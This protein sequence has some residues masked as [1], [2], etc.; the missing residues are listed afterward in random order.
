MP[1]RMGQRISRTA[2]ANRGGAAVR[3]SLL[4]LLLVAAPALA[5]AEI[6]RFLAQLQP[7]DLVPGADRFG[8]IAGDPPAAPAYRGDEL[9][10]YVFLNSDA[11]NSSGYSGKPIHIAVGMTPQGQIT[12]AMLLEHHEPIVLIGIPEKRMTGFIQDY[13]GLDVLG[14]T[15]ADQSPVDAI[16]GATVTVMVIDDTLRRASRRVLHAMASGATGASE[17]PRRRLDLTQSGSQGWDQLLAEASVS[18]LRLTVGDVNEAFEKLG[19]KAAQRRERGAAGETFIDL[20]VALASAP[21]VGR[22]LL[23]GNEYRLLR[24]RLEAGHHAV[25]IGGRGRYSW[26]GS[27]YVRG[28][29]FDR[30]KLIQGEEVIR[31]RDSDYKRIGDFVAEGAPD[32]PEIGLFTLPPGVTFDPSQPWRLELLVQRA[33]GALE[34]RFIAFD[35]TYT[36]PDKYLQPAARPV[37][38]VTATGEA[39]TPAVEQ[40][41][42]QRLWQIK[43]LQIAILLAGLAVLTLIF[44]FQDWL[45][46]RPKLT[47]RVRI[48]FLL[49]TLLWI[50]WY[51]DAQLSVVNVLALFNALITDFSWDYF[52]VDPLVFILWTAVAASLLFWGRGPFCGWLCPFGALQELL[53]RVAK[54]LRVPQYLVP[55]GLHE[56]LWP[57]KY[58]IF[59]GLFGVSLYSLADAEVFAEVEPFKTA[60]ILDFV[61]EWPFVVYAAVLL[62]AGLFIERFFCRYLCPL[63]AALAIPGRLRMFEWLKRYHQ[64]GNPCQR[65]ANECMVQSIHPDGHINPNECHYCLHCQTL[66]YDD[67]RCP[68]V[69]QKRLKKERAEALSTKIGTAGEPP[70]TSTRPSSVRS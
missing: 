64:C 16:S 9:V 59:L 13:V 58:I 3:C 20:Y 28:G 21:V 41:L 23:G 65:C 29:I 54:L 63:G 6:E 61:R 30:V 10:G 51:A 27:G 8:A 69:I 49:F 1:L 52:L 47:D 60:I 7:A 33:T 17:V 45:V 70:Q 11:V 18:H 40:P 24:D 44:F 56:R 31:F 4:L 68:V 15:A 19:G 34:K 53:N 26:R 62:I 50:G 14:E 2:C 67:R 48:G 25:L 22:S 42:W 43:T 38:Q 66:Y 57:L 32:L 36:L 37:P 39:P 12:G 5:A 46:R 55:W 35:A